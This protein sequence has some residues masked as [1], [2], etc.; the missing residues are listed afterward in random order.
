MCASCNSIVKKL[1]GTSEPTGQ[2]VKRDVLAKHKAKS[3]LEMAVARDLAVELLLS[4]GNTPIIADTVR[5]EYE[6]VESRLG[7]SPWGTWA[8]HLFRSEEFVPVGFKE[9]TR[10]SNHARMM[11]SWVLGGV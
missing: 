9:A 6:Q 3:A 10:M 2:D 8:G 5:D 11:R 4:N 7:L 1:M